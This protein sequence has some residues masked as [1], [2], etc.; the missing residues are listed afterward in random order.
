MKTL[1]QFLKDNMKDVDHQMEFID[2]FYKLVNKYKVDGK[3]IYK[4]MNMSRQLYSRIISGKVIPSLKSALKLALGIRCNNNECK[5]LLKKVGYTL[6]SSNKFALII[7]YCFENQIYDY[8][9][10]NKL[11]TENGC[12]ALD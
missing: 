8:F 9:E 6:P 4:R 10:I 7:R 1:E 11:L 5:L 3:D 12:E 2:Y